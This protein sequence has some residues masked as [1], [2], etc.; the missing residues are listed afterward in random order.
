LDL[1]LNV[2]DGERVLIDFVAFASALCMNHLY[3]G[4]FA[5]NSGT[6]G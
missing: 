1:G 5:S 6:R 2:D 4:R 3:K